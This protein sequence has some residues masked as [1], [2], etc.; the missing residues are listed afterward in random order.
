MEAKKSIQYTWLRGGEKNKFLLQATADATGRRVVGGPIEG[1]G[2]G[3]ILMQAIGAGDVEG[4]EQAREI[5][6]NS[7]D[8]VTFEP[9]VSYSD[10]WDEAY[11][12]FLKIL[13]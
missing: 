6:R 9:F 10:A 13:E 11:G 3:N 5:V 2:V 1:T 12:R 7:F 8:V 4:V